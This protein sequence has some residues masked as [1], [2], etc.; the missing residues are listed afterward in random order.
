AMTGYLALRDTSGPG[1]GV[2]LEYYEPANDQKR[3]EYDNFLSSLLTFYLAEN[4]TVKD[5]KFRLKKDADAMCADMSELVTGSVSFFNHRSRQ[6]FGGFSNQLR[7]AIVKLEREKLEVDEFGDLGP[8]KELLRRM[9]VD[10]RINALHTAAMKEVRA[11]SSSRLM[12]LSSSDEATLDPETMERI[13]EEMLAYDPNAPLQP[14][15]GDDEDKM[16]RITLQDNSTLTLPEE[17]NAAQDDF[18]QK[19]YALLE[20]QNA[21]LDNMQAQI[22]QVRTDQLAMWKSQ[23]E[24]TNADLQ[25]QISDL[26]NIVVQLVEGISGK[27]ITVAPV[28]PAPTLP[29]AVVANLPPSVTVT[30]AKNSDDL[31]S[32][33]LLSLNELVDILARNPGISV[34]ITGH[35]DRTGTEMQNLVLSNQRA[36]SVKK[37]FTNAGLNST[38][39][40]TQYLGQRDSPSENP[41][42]RKVTLTFVAGS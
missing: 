21:K 5:D 2:V 17:P 8:G 30:F 4:I 24:K 7:N 15:P 12:T 10:S 14:L 42:D 6:P 33:A 16:V 34:I 37:F 31:N 1:G 23:Q 18:A 38:R 39:F 3:E 29:P 36:Q 22:D 40:V 27:P 28:T 19:V 9:V 11:F 26:R 20:Q 41:A 32:I 25:A 13:V 35:A